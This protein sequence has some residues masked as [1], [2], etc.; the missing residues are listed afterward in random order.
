MPGASGPNPADGSPAGRGVARSSGPE[1]R[2]PQI[3]PRRRTIPEWARCRPPGRFNGGGDSTAG[4]DS[5]ARFDSTALDSTARFDSTAGPDSTGIRA[6]ERARGLFRRVRLDDLRA[7]PDRSRC[8]GRR[9][10]TRRSEEGKDRDA[11]AGDGSEGESFAEVGPRRPAC[12]TRLAGRQPH[13]HAVA[14]RRLLDP[15]LVRTLVRR[16]P[17]GARLRL[18]KIAARSPTA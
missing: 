7:R 16:D 3:H 11:K 10:Q 17:P 14:R 1:W 18:R 12:H 5:I 4:P 13:P 9:G 2:R 6:S 15:P 8:S